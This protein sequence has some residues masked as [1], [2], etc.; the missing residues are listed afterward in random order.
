EDT[1]PQA[2]TEHIIEPSNKASG[3]EA[4]AFDKLARSEIRIAE[5]IMQGYTNPEMASIMNTTV[6]TVKSYRKSLY[7]K[8]QIHS[9]QELFGL[10]EKIEK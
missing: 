3:L 6:N 10:A 8:L 2:P 9:R 7:S 1:E 5:L 4:H